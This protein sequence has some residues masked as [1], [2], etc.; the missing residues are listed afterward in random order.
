M[1]NNNQT[2]DDIIISTENDEHLKVIP[3][4]HLPKKISNELPC[5]NESFIKN[6]ID[7]LNEKIHKANE[8]PTREN[9]D[10][11]SMNVCEVLQY[12]EKTFGLDYIEDFAMKTSVKKEAESE[13]DFNEY[14]VPIVDKN[15]ERFV[16]DDEAGSRFEKF[17]GI[18]ENRSFKK[19]YG[20]EL[21]KIVDNLKE[22]VYF[23][24][25]MIEQ[26]TIDHSEK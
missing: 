8:N 17:V 7:P 9:M 22:T 15:G 23:N 13:N 4:V 10:K 24:Q 6:K 16:S 5:I 20:K 2:I 3:K 19:A 25:E 1:E 14:F 12:V 26:K 11:V 21:T 18:N